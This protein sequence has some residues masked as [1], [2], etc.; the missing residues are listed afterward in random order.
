MSWGLLCRTSCL[1]RAGGAGW[2]PSAP[3]SSH[4][5]EAAMSGGGCVGRRRPGAI[6][7]RRR[8]APRAGCERHE[9]Q[10]LNDQHQNAP[11]F[12]TLG[13]SRPRKAKESKSADTILRGSLSRGSVVPP[14]HPSTLHPSSLISHPPRILSGYRGQAPSR[15]DPPRR[16]CA[17]SCSR[18][19]K[20]A[21]RPWP[22]SSSPA[23]SRRYALTWRTSFGA[24]RRRSHSML[25]R[26]PRSSARRRKCASIASRAGRLPNAMPSLTSWRMSFP[27]LRNAAPLEKPSTRRSHSS[28]SRPR[29]SRSGVD[30][31]CRLV[32]LPLFSLYAPFQI[33]LHPSSFILHPS[34]SPGAHLHA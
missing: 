1:R 15:R 33:L 2:C 26:G 18:T 28:R 12:E 8:A 17:R 22:A 11:V 21:L 30:E 27:I 9:Q 4:P 34:S 25:R 13:R 31:T 3:S 24:H 6:Q 23:A 32:R 14:L 20:P 10:T 7:T 16:L 5:P 19:R 29:R